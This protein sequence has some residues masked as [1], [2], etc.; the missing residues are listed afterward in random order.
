MAAVGGRSS[1]KLTKSNKK[2]LKGIT[3]NKSDD[4]QE[5][6]NSIEGHNNSGRKGLKDDGDAKSPLASTSSPNGSRQLFFGGTFFF[7]R[8]L[9]FFA[10][11]VCDI[12]IGYC[13]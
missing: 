11:C 9:G 5:D 3:V 10:L 6:C 8:F 2:K 1:S 7:S 13:F 4:D 12:D